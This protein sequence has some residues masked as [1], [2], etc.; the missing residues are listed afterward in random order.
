MYCFHEL[1]LG[2]FPVAGVVFVVLLCC[3]SFRNTLVS[4]N[5]INVGDP[6][7]TPI[8]PVGYD[9]SQGETTGMLQTLNPKP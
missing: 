9:Q 5:L 8:G 7:T 3:L 6:S 1:C 2:V 4:L